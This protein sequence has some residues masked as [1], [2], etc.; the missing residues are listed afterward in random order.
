VARLTAELLR[1][2]TERQSPVAITIYMPVHTVH[3]PPAM[4]EDQIRFKN[5]L[6]QVRETI[7]G[8]PDIKS[9]DAQSVYIRLEQLLDNLVFW[10]GQRLG[11]AVFADTMAVTTVE[12]PI[13]C[14]SYAAVDESFHFAP[15]IGLLNELVTYRVLVVSEKE[16]LLFEGDSYGLRL[17]KLA[18]PASGHSGS[19]QIR[20][21]RQLSHLAPHRAD[22][23]PEYFG[24]AFPVINSDERLNFF[25]SIDRAVQA[26][27][28]PPIPLLLAGTETDIADFRAVTTYANILRASL[29]NVI[30]E[31]GVLKLV[32]QSAATVRREVRLPAVRSLENRY[33]Q[34]LGNGSGLASHDPDVLRQAAAE[35]RIETLL[36]KMIQLTANTIRPEPADVPKLVFG[37]AELMPF[38]NSLATHVRRTGG[39]TVLTRLAP[40]ADPHEAPLAT[41]IFRY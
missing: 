9:T 15:V 16:P 6:G 33:E 26:A 11:L 19:L 12:L 34:L 5:L 3:T 14:D 29:P 27:G 32:N 23:Q 35:G 21:K 37:P 31:A 25:R 17:T 10:E 36:L 40:E 4:H 13:D 28:Q 39:T 24:G 8:S 20:G 41:A 22:A 38:T 7:A 18:L 1:Q 2:L 30:T